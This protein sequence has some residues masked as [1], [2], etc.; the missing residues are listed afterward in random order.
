M[1]ML[2]TASSLGGAREA[3]RTS[4]GAQIPTAARLTL[5]RMNLLRHM[6]L[7]FPEEL[8]IEAVEVLES[9][10]HI[11][12]YGVRRRFTIGN[13]DFSIE[14]EVRL[15]PSAVAAAGHRGHDVDELMRERTLW[16][17]ASYPDDGYKL[18]RL[19]D[20]SPIVIDSDEVPDQV[21]GRL[22]A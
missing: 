1:T 16:L 5:R 20:A 9:R 18:D 11:N 21:Q 22:A 6:N 19:E 14:L 10:R 13:G 8:E 3:P 12:G 4:A 7:V 2:R 17:A 15:T